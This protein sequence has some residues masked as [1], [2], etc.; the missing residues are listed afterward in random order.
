MFTGDLMRCFDDKKKAQLL[1]YLTDGVVLTKKLEAEYEVISRESAKK[2]LNQFAQ[3]K[4][5]IELKEISDQ[6][7]SP[8]VFSLEE[9]KKSF[10]ISFFF[11]VSFVKK[12]LQHQTT[13]GIQIAQNIRS[14]IQD[15]ISSFLKKYDVKEDKEFLVRKALEEWKP[16]KH[17]HAR[18]KYAFGYDCDSTEILQALKHTNLDESENDLTNFI[19]SEGLIYLIKKS[20]NVDNTFQ[21]NI[22]LDDNQLF[23]KITGTY[24]WRIDRDNIEDRNNLSDSDFLFFDDEDG[25]VVFDLTV[26][27]EPLFFDKDGDIIL[28]GV[29]F[30]EENIPLIASDLMPE[31]IRNNLEKD[32]FKAI[33][34]ENFE[35]VSLITESL[36]YYQNLIISFNWV[37]EVIEDLQ[38]RTHVVSFTGPELLIRLWEAFPNQMARIGLGGLKNE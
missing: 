13:L 36:E 27:K 18:E 26:F 32:L 23:L 35:R 2:M 28:K 21:V 8:I 16:D 22:Q 5:F 3:E 37:L 31:D 1:A 17:T 20:A 15:S 34:A 4:R 25:I 10:R 33:E 19:S 24:A 29:K 9:I 14:I 7:A 6:L 11:Y 30:N 38:K 12:A